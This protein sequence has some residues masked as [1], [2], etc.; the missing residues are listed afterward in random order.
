MQATKNETDA[1]KDAAMLKE[2][3]LMAGYIEK[4]HRAKADGKKI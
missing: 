4:I 3:E 2:K 1:Y